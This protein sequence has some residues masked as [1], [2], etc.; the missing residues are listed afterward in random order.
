MAAACTDLLNLKQI[1]TSYSG[2]A[3][4]LFTPCIWMRQYLINYAN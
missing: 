4:I 3:I 1:E 2:S